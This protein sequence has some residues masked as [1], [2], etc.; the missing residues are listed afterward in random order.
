MTKAAA[1]KKTS[2]SS[3]TSTRARRAP[4]R[5]LPNSAPQTC[6]PGRR[7]ERKERPGGRC[8]NLTIRL[9]WPRRESHEAIL[10]PIEVAEDAALIRAVI[11]AG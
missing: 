9:F 1:P 2:L 4:I 5:L 10:K 11:A 6:S 7:K 3:A 8:S